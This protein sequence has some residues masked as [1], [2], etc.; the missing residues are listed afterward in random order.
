MK[1]KLKTIMFVTGIAFIAFA[2]QNPVSL[3]EEAIDS[4]TLEAQAD[5]Y[6]KNVLDLYKL[7]SQA[8][9]NRT[10]AASNQSLMINLFDSISIEKD[11]K[12]LTFSDL[13][14]QDK[15]IFLTEWGKEETR[16]LQEKIKKD[17]GVGCHLTV[18]NEALAEAISNA[19][20]TG[21]M[22]NFRNFYQ[23]K[24][25]AKQK[26]VTSLIAAVKADGSGLQ[27]A[28]RAGGIS[29]A[30][31]AFRTYYAKGRILYASGS[32]SITG[33]IGHISLMT[34]APAWNYA[35]ESNHDSRIATGA[36]GDDKYIHIGYT[37]KGVGLESLSYW[38]NEVEQALN[39][40]I[41][42]CQAGNNV[43]VWNWFNSHW[44]FRLPSAAETDRA[45]AYARSKIG[46]PFN[47]NFLW[48]YGEDS[49]Y[50]SQLVWRSWY[51]AD[52]KYDLDASPVDLWVFPNDV[53][54]SG[55][56][57]VLF[58]VDHPNL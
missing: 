38:L 8:G 17:P 52:H 33:F 16:Q 22:D 58:G 7:E 12:Q 5:L 45:C 24:L 19:T 42:I 54:H 28:S 13:D 2:C 10:V 23:D 44:E 34:E 25:L 47:Y 27:P 1:T 39:D 21:S 56:C 40:M 41:L 51:N 11:G 57:R 49:F 3:T 43:W 53:T 26:K 14:D 9:M 36:W 20:Q 32:S 4:G 30:I 55:D 35:W 6:V 46:L 50:C 15:N 48:K 29:N 37:Q 18:R 31:E